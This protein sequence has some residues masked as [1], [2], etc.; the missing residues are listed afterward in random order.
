MPGAAPRLVTQNRIVSPAE[1]VTLDDVEVT[2]P[3]DPVVPL[4]VPIVVVPDDR[5]SVH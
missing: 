1:A 2:V 4:K 5:V 3:A